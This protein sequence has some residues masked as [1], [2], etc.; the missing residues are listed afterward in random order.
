VLEQEYMDYIG[1]SYPSNHTY[2]IANGKLLPKCKLS[3][4]HRKIR[5]LF[6]TNLTSLVDVGCSKGFFILSAKHCP[7]ALG[8]DVNPYDISVCQWASQQVNNQHAQ[9]KYLKLHEFAEQIDQHGGAFQTVLV[10]NIYQYLYFGSD[11]YPDCYLDHDTIF[12]DLRKICSDRV[13]FNNRV[14]LEDCQNTQR[15]QHSKDH[16]QHYSKEKIIEAASRYFTVEQHGNIGRYPLWV[17]KIK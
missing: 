16:S 11:P 15:I 17:L 8:I 9:F 12:R 2:K 4:R 5:S 6:P 14:D 10:V 1:S 3:I 7:R 13:I